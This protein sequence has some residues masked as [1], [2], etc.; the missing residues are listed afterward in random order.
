M[1]RVHQSF[2]FDSGVLSWKFT[3][4]DPEHERHGVM[5]HAID[6]QVMNDWLRR[7]LRGLD[8]HLV[9]AEEHVLPTEGHTEYWAKRASDADQ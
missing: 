4:T 5:C 9:C 7:C 8:Y 3:A 1:I 6:S 2:D